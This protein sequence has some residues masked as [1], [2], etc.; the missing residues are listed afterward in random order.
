MRCRLIL[1]TLLLYL[2]GWAQPITGEAKNLEFKKDRIVYTGN[3]KLTRGDSVLH[4]DKVVIFLDER[5]K[6]VKMVAT[7]KVRYFEPRR[8]AFSRYAEYDLVKDVI[9]LKGN[10][11]VEED[12]NVL[13]ADEIVY[14]KKNETLQAKGDKS[15]VRTIY[16]EEEKNEK[17]GH[18]EGDSP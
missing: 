3:V 13:E 18:N 4:A 15:K 12:K 16:I 14:D 7:G 10:A 8:K 6:P 1:L 9:I 17:I 11:R 2:W 5:G